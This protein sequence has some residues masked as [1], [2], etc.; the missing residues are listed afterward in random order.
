MGTIRGKSLPLHITVIK[1]YCIAVCMYVLYYIDD[2]TDDSL[3]AHES[4]LD[5]MRGF[6]ADNN[7]IFKLI[8]KR[9]SLWQQK[10]DMDVSHGLNIDHVTVT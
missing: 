6:F 3:S 9:E 4:E 5:K 7:E 8:E 2:Y 1:V 10:I